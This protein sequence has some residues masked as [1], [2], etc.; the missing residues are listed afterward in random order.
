MSRRYRS[1]RQKA[2]SAVARET[3]AAL[4][5]ILEA[6][7]DFDAINSTLHK[8]DD[9]PRLKAEDCPRFAI[10]ND[11]DSQTA[12]GIVTRVVND[13]TLDTAVRMYQVPGQASVTAAEFNTAT[14]ASSSSS[15]SSSSSRVCVLNLASD[16]HPGGG[17]LKGSLAQEEAICYRSS[18]YLSLYKRYYPL[19]P[20]SAIYTPSVV[21]IRDAYGDGHQLITDRQPSELDVVSIVSIAALRRP[22]TT[23]AQKIIDGHISERDVFAKPKDRELTKQKMRLTLRVAASHGHT[24]LVLGALGCGAFKNPSEEV[25]MCWREVLGESEFQGGWFEHVVFAVLDKGS[26]GKNAGKGGV[27]NFDT[28]ERILGGVAFVEG[29]DPAKMEG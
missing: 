27:G 22:E 13:D 16:M 17:W 5:L 2:L 28:F 9:L 26:D 14:A 12:N 11:Q 3:K 8:L 21:I 25:A 18:L 19:G 10:T 1:A 7:P 4:P 6:L 15:S 23:R 29:K 20:T 24:R